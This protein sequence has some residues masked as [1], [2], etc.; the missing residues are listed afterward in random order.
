MGD[1]KWNKTIMGRENEKI[2]VKEGG[3]KKGRKNKIEFFFWCWCGLFYIERP[4]EG[5]GNRK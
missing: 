3:E 4:K 2:I 1:G 5:G